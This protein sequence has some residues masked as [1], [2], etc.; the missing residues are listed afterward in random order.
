MKVEF[1]TTYAQTLSFLKIKDYSICY[2][3]WIDYEFVQNDTFVDFIKEVLCK[4]LLNRLL[5]SQ[6]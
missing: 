1:F 3:N 2:L 6:L 4:C 5:L